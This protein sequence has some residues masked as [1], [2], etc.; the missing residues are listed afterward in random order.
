M[1]SCLIVLHEDFTSFKKGYQKIA[2]E[3][4]ELLSAKYQIDL[5]VPYYFIKPK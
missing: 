3:R 2:K 5:F 1:Q 4:I